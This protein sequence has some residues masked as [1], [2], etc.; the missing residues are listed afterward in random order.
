[1]EVIE[2][3]DF[4]GRLESGICDYPFS[5]MEGIAGFIHVMIDI[6]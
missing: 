2:S 1:M 4:Q 5:L 6:L 3:Y